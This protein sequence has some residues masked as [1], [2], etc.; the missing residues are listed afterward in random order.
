MGA[1]RQK[2]SSCFLPE[3]F[4]KSY[5]MVFFWHLCVRRALWY[6]HRT[7]RGSGGLVLSTVVGHY[8]YV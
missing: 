7:T 5:N 8:G 1:G 6:C 2:E 3:P 4:N